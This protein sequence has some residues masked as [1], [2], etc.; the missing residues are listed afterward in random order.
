MGFMRAVSASAIPVLLLCACD[1]E[2]APPVPATSLI[3]P[4]AE[5]PAVPASAP[6]EV[7]SAAAAAA[8]PAP[9]AALAAA[10][11]QWDGVVAEVV[12][13][14][15]RGNTL[16]AKV[17]FRNEGE[18]EPE[19]D[20]FYTEVYLM[21]AAGGKKY[22]VLKDEDGRYIAALR[23]GNPS[24]WYKRL[25][26]GA[27]QTIWMKFPAPPEEVRTITLQVPGIPPFEEL[28]IEDVG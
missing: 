16:T 13:F 26:P 5:Q 28:P 20:L 22:E 18:E 25:S 15:R 3:P 11:T 21:D 14:R 12:E 19:V 23:S 27:S 8:V 24:R 2:A 9:G 17:R 7:A 1:R 10:E 4:G 6:A